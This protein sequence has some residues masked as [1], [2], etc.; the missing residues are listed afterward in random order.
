MFW[1]PPAGWS[2]I[3][4]K[5]SQPCSECGR[6]LG[7]GEEHLLKKRNSKKGKRYRFRCVDTQDCFV[8]KEWGGHPVYRKRLMELAARMDR[9]R[10]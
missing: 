9:A 5:K 3:T 2:V 8:V 6:S 7:R 4:L 1:K 10:T